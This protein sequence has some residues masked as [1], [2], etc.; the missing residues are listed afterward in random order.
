MT[1]ISTQSNEFQILSQESSNYQVVNHGNLGNNLNSSQNQ[2]YSFGNPI[3]IEGYQNIVDLKRK[4]K[5]KG[6]CYLYFICL[7]ALFLIYSTIRYLIQNN[8]L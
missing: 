5:T 7:L 8:R 3:Q 6:K 1:S 4:M 2:A